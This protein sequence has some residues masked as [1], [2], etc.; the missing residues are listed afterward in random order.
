MILPI[1]IIS[2]N[3]SRKFNLNSP[4]PINLTVSVTFRCNS[5]CK[6]C[7]IYKKESDE[8]SSEEFDKIFKS[9]GRNKLYW[10]TFSGGEVFLRNDFVNICESAYRNCQPKVITIPTNGLLFDIIPERIR[11]ILE[12]C[13][14]TKVVVNLSLDDIKEKHDFIR[15]IEGNFDKALNTY[16]GLKNLRAPNLVLGV[17]TVISKFN[18]KR[19]PEIYDFVMNELSPDSYIT[20]IAEEREELGT[21]GCDI[22]PLEKDYCDSIDFLIDKIKNRKF[23]GLAKTTEAFRLNYYDMVK[24]ILRNQAQAIPCY[25]GI[26]SS[27]ITPDGD[28]WACCIKAEKMGNLVEAN[29]DFKKVWNSKKS[30]E[31]RKRIKNAGCFCPLANSS[32]TNML[33][34][35]NCL[36]KILGKY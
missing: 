19:I 25:A 2:Y 23:K 9:I 32:Y 7:N 13:K 29:Y 4:L 28:V 22:K 21:I 16:Q 27:H 34:N 18:V 15:G 1:K 24:R 35:I 26:A 14:K 11:R 31:I 3:L 6:T 8:L 5:R 17:H 12:I 30:E 10:I 36:L 33:L 20:E